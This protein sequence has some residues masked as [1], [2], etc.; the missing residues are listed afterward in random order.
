MQYISQL[1]LS[2]SQAYAS[3]SWQACRSGKTHQQVACKVMHTVNDIGGYHGLHLLLTSLVCYT[4]SQ[5]AASS[6]GKTA[7]NAGRHQ[8]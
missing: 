5:Q 1:V 7:G 6:R 8:H 3:L 2:Y 4:D